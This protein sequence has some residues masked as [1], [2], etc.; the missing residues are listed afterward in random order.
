MKTVK[1]SIDGA[2]PYTYVGEITHG[3]YVDQ[4]RIKHKTIRIIGKCVNTGGDVDITFNEPICK[5]NIF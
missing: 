1:V 5:W 2:Y 3:I 4:H